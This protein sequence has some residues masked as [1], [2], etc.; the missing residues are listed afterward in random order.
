MIVFQNI[1]IRNIQGNINSF[2]LGKK[3]K[4]HQIMSNIFIW[5]AIGENEIDKND[6]E[7]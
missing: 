7:K 6:N 1:L 3:T 5:Y 4:P 2:S